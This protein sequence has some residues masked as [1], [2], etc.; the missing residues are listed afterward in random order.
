VPLHHDE[1]VNG[2]FLVTLVRERT[3]FYDPQNYHGRRFITSQQSFPGLSGSLAA[4][5]GDTY[6]LTTSTSVW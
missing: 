3:Y 4:R 5:R 1:G 6:G 2:N